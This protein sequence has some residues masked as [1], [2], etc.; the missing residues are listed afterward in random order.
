MRR[1]GVLTNPPKSGS[2]KRK[3]VS[4]DPKDCDDDEAEEQRP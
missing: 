2:N 3:I 1:V 4:Q